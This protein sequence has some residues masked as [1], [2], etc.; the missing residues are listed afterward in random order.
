MI[1][2]GT[3]LLGKALIDSKERDD[4]V[5]VTYLGNYTV[6]D[7]GEIK[8]L[9]L[10]ILDQAG[11]EKIF[12]EFKP[13]V[14][15]HTASIG[16][17]DY[18]E[19]HQELTWSINVDGT[20]KLAELCDRHGARLIYIS[21]NGIYDGDQA[22]YSEDAIARPI[23][24]Y[25]RTK[26][27]GERRALK[28]RNLPAIVR[29]ILMYGWNNT[30]ERDNIVSMS[31]KKFNK[32]ETVKAYDDVFSNSLLADECARA[33]WRII[34]TKATGAFNIAGAERASIYALLRTA[35]KIFGFAEDL[36]K[37]VKQGYFN[38]LVKRPV[39][40]SYDTTK[41]EKVLKIAPLSLVEG[42]TRMKAAQK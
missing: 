20:D 36:V 27:E 12:R 4:E 38:E 26:L 21:S 28:A 22:P 40:T 39:D 8:Y 37:P 25:G 35:A 41:M 9:K 34:E 1:T 17:P 3:G 19:Q 11:H 29:P 30:Y 18:A 10:D 14:V 23:N 6:P 42:L 16:S 5:L 2:G 24:Y 15:I 7:Q 33:I 31:L 13:E 32:G